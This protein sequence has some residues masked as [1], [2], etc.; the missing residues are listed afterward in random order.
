MDYLEPEYAEA[1]EGW[2]NNSTPEGNSSILNTID[3]IVRKGTSMFG[4]ESPLTRSR[5][6]KLALEGLGTYDRSRSRL[7]S[8]LINQLKGLQRISRK[9]QEVV[10]APER[11]LL[12]KFKLNKYEQTFLDEKGRDPTDNELSNTSGFSLKRIKHV[13]KWQPGMTTSRLEEISPNFAGGSFSGD[14]KSQASWL[15]VVYDSLSPMDQKVMELSLGLHGR[16]PLS[17]SQIAASLR[18]TPG[19]ISQRKKKI[20]A[21]IR[22][23]EGLSPFIG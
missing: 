13:R 23:E 8:H 22:E 17:N 9:Q 7:Q 3:P 10:R 16:K 14:E 20:Q 15:E 21:I 19:A 4:G 18:R 5:A 1:Y 6:R 12:D 11:V 2:K